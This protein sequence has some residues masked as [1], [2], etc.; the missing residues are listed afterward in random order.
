MAE[1]FEE[2]AELRRA[3]VS[4]QAQIPVIRTFP[5]ITGIVIEDRR[6]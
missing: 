4:G 2:V 6:D 1:L 3:P 5:S